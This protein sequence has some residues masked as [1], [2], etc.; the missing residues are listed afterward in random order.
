MTSHKK[1]KEKPKKREKNLPYGHAQTLEAKTKNQE[2]KRSD[3]ICHQ[4]TP[5]L[6]SNGIFRQNS[7]GE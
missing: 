3:Q 4:E 2:R 5:L 7:G 1:E 6:T